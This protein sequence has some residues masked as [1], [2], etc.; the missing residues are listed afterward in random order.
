MSPIAAPADRR[1]HRVHVKP[2][3]RRRDWRWMA[4]PVVRYGL[5]AVVVTYGAHHGA[6]L[7]AGARALQVAN[8]VVRGNDRLATDEV[9]AV[10]TGLRG[11]SLVWTDLE[12]WRRRLLASP[13]VREAA[14]RRSF[15]ST[16]EV[17]VLERQPIGVG[18]MNDD[19]YLV[20]DG[21]AIIDGFGPQYA[22]LDLPLIDGL[23]T[24]GD[25]SREM[26]DQ[27]RAELASRL[28]AALKVSPGIAHRLSQVDVGDPHNASVLL[29]GDSTAIHVGEDQFL[30][31]LQAYVDLAAVLHARFPDIDYVDLRFDGRIYV[32][33]AGQAPED[34][35]S[36]LKR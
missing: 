8:I 27:R 4:R 15:P 29:A 23:S 30:S 16:V 11:E 34:V 28:I 33:P 5:A 31:R 24:P 17:M 1:F 9:L 7:V 32:R 10:L 14:L 35:G 2:A 3:R 6:I 12:K 18:R 13:W 26:A 20:D 19:L 22:D 21:G 25:V 36:R